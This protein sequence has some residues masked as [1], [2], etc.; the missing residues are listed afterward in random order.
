M[1]LQTW[2]LALGIAAALQSPVV[3]AQSAPI[4]QDQAIRR[5]LDASPELRASAENRRA[6]AGAR[7][8]ASVRPNP[9]LQIEAENFAGSDP[10]NGLSAGEYTY[11]LGQKIE[12]GGKRAARIAIAD[13][14]AEFA[15]LD[16]A[17]TELD[18]VMAVRSAYVSAMAATARRAVAEDQQKIG[19]ELENSVRRRVASARDPEAALLRISAHTLELKADRD[20]ASETTKIAKARLSSYWG[21]VTNAFD[22]DT[23][24][25]FAAPGTVRSI[26]TG[27][28]ASPDA[29]LLSASEARA[30][31][32]LRLEQANARQDPTIS[33][34]VRHLAGD[35]AVAGVVSFSM[36]LALFDTN[37]GTISKAR[38]E[39]NRAEWEK[40]AGLMRLTRDYQTV[41]GRLNAAGAE[42]RAIREEIIPKA[43]A[44]L[45][46]ARRGFDRGA[47]TY[48]DVIEAQRA[49]TDLKSREIAALTRLRQSEIALDRL[50]GRMSDNGE[51]N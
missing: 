12:R 4:T 21:E 13:A 8:Q 41:L 49:L 16:E 20:L 27:V 46:A 15:R 39:R 34:G 23:A 10:F 44:A 31:A 48:L 47:F 35:D 40:R 3:V 51:T 26:P 45:Q 50:A 29:A 2:G 32:A 7:L 9:T 30:G 37:K 42:A 11:S 36:P 43:E 14:D 38:A 6:A 28:E 19:V 22:I 5:A 18:V 33:F 1:R 24:L 17:R 25:L